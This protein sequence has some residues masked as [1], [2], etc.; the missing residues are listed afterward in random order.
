M[1]RMSS[2]RLY[3]PL[4]C[5]AALLLSAACRRAPQELPGAATEPAAMVR[6]LAGHLRVNVL[7]G[8]VRAAVPPS[9]YADLEAA[10]A[11]GPSRW[12]LN[13]LR[14]GLNQLS[15]PAQLCGA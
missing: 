15:L 5:L 2:P 11:H 8:Y 7:V 10:W 13:E 1:P 12:P 4:L 6:Q 14:P 9:Q 3:L